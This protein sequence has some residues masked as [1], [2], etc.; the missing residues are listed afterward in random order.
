M[1]DEVGVQSKEELQNPVEGGAKDEVSAH[2][3]APPSWKKL[4]SPKKG[5]T[6]RKNEVIFIAPTGEEISNRKQLE[7]YLKSHPVDV[8]LSDFDWSTGETP[9]RSARI[10]EK[11]KTTPPP[12][13]DP[14]RKRARKSP[15]SKK[16]EAKNSEGVKETDVK[17]VEM[18]EKEH[19]EIKKEKDKEPKMVDET[20]EKETENAKD[21]EPEKDIETA[22]D[23]QAENVVE[24]KDEPGIENVP[25][26]TTITKNGQLDAEDGK[27]VEDQSHGN[28][29][30]QE[31]ATAVE[32]VALVGGQDK[33]ENRPQTEAEKANESCCMKQEKADASN[34]KENG[35][36][37][38]P[39][40][41][42]TITE[43]D[44]A[45][46]H[47]IQAKDRVNKKESEVIETAMRSH[48][49]WRGERSIL[50]KD[51]ETSP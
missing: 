25:G 50:Y 31:V 8:A 1:E 23:E 41:E 12:Q 49:G 28:V 34:I 22:K 33:G 7:Q 44:D 4:L 21:E 42:G 36:A 19:A 11:A 30:N 24:T 29:Q 10:S 39:A 5:G 47:D 46:K 16:K 3:P 15:G 6:P 13:E 27:E 17:D 37:G 48:I 14:P 35:V 20:K 51:V 32:S 38:T 45:Q 26:N 9:R 43:N 18:S 40:S 2:L